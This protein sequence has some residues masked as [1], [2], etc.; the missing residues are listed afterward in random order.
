VRNYFFFLFFFKE[1]KN[2]TQLN[3]FPPTRGASAGA[4]SKELLLLLFIFLQRIK[5]FHPIEWVP[6]YARR[7]GGRGE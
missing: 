6:T 1:L 7:F 2:F 3:G 4:V 5:E